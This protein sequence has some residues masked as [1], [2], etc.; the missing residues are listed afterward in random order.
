MKIRARVGLSAAIAV[1]VVSL[2]S[3]T[4]RPGVAQ[5]ASQVDGPYAYGY[6]NGF[7][8]YGGYGA[9]GY[10]AYWSLSLGTL[11]PASIPPQGTWAE[12]INV[13]PKWLVLQDQQGRQFPVD[14]RSIKQFLVRWQSSASQLTSES[15]VEVT[16][17]DAGS[18]VVVAD[19]IDVFGTD[20]QKLV[21]PDYQPLT[22]QNRQLAGLQEDIVNNP[23]GQIYAPPGA[24]A[25]LPNKVNVVGR[26]MGN[27][28][29]RIQTFGTNSVVVQPA[30][31]GMTVTEITLGSNSY[32][33]KG[34]LVY[35]V[36]DSAGQRSL[37]LSQ[38]VLYKKVAFRQFNP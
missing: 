21:T 24:E 16:G 28:P 27:D 35:F 34:D 11:R 19:H 17:I 5:V 31:E 29:V 14:A 8:T 4:A 2:G 1:L 26:A 13:T 33:K 36:T 25:S 9:F 10:G 32:A 22:G 37:T 6:Y 12:V 3:L 7:G 38:I 20:A 30:L 18:N 15:L 23:N